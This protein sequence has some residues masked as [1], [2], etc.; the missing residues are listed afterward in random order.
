M[1]LTE[2]CL[3]ASAGVKGLNHLYPSYVHIPLL[4]FQYTPIVVCACVCAC[5]SFLCFHVTYFTHVTMLILIVILL[6]TLLS[7]VYVIGQLEKKA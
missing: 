4:N 1:C 7:C 3:Q 2:E 6:L 5:A